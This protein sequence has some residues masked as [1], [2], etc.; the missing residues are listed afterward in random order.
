MTTEVIPLTGGSV[1][2]HQ[3][4][5]IQLGDNL[6]SFTLNFVQSGQWSTDLRIEGVLVAA[7]SM[8]EPNADIIAALNLGI[9]QL[10]FLGENTTLDNLGTENSL[11]WISPDE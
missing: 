4:F 7:G 8:L 6:V 10:I 5:S 3:A 9:G 11:I 2:A 1:N